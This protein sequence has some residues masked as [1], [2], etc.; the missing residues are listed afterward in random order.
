M[1][2]RRGAA[3]VETMNEEQGEKAMEIDFAEALGTVFDAP[4]CERCAKADCEM[5]ELVA[6]GDVTVFGCPNYKP[7]GATKGK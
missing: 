4:R 2:S 7:V 3:L 5:K 6:M 1:K